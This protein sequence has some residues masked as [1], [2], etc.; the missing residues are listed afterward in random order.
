[1]ARRPAKRL[2]G[3]RAYQAGLA[4]EESV[5]RHYARRGH[6]IARRRWRGRAGEIDL[7]AEDGDALI[8]VEVKQSRSFDSAME[9]LTPR[10]VQRLAS[11][12]EEYLG[13]MPRGQL[14]DIRFDVALVNGR[15]EMRVLENAFA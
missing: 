6:P 15:G 12:A 1:M 3:A 10:Q 9:H 14:T 11:A 4:A 2:Q 5:A 7:I 13:Q 8:F